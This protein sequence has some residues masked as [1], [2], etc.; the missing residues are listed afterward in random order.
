M[1]RD[2]LA[3]G[4]CG[5]IIDGINQNTA[6]T[7]GNR[8]IVDRYNMVQGYENIYALGDIACMTDRNGY[9]QDAQVAIQQATNICR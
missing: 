1:R 7:K 4:I 2:M 9:P 6:I 8:L 3:A 5:N